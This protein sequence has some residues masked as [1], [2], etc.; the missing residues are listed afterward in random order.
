VL[1]AFN[2]RVIKVICLFSKDIPQHPVEVPRLL[3][4]HQLSHVEQVVQGGMFH[5]AA[6]NE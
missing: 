5:L 1:E 3:N 2:G 4:A 6:G